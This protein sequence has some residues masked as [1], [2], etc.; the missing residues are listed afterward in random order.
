METS[1]NTESKAQ[2]EDS[3]LEYMANKHATLANDYKTS[4]GKTDYCVS[5]AEQ[6]FLMLITQGKVPSIVKVHN[7]TDGKNITPKVF[8]GRI[9]WGEH[10]ICCE[11][12]LAYDPMVSSKPVKLE[13]YLKTA[14][15]E[16]VELEPWSVSLDNW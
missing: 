11:S 16:D 12:S 10:H 2:T 8:N 9:Q 7:K 14:F 1:T 13:D 3:V 4:D 15:E 6:L 5:I